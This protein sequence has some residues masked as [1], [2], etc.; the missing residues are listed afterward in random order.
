MFE[1]YIDI[2]NAILLGDDILVISTT[3]D[4]IVL[5]IYVKDNL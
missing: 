1:I 2:N 3:V 5:N 4:F